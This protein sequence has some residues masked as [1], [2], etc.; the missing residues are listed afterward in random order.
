MSFSPLL[1]FAA[2]CWVA[3]KIGYACHDFYK[4]PEEVLP[5]LNALR[6]ANP[7]GNLDGI[8]IA[9]EGEKGE[10]LVLFSECIGWVG[11]KAIYRYHLCTNW[12]FDYW[13][14]RAYL[15][16]FIAICWK[17]GV[18][19]RG[20]YLPEMDIKRIASG[21]MLVCTE[22]GSPGVGGSRLWHP[23]DMALRPDEFI[24]G[25][26]SEEDQFGIKSALRLW[27]DLE[28][29]GY[30]DTGLA[31]YSKAEIRAAYESMLRN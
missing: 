10:A 16:A 29:Q 5:F 21:E 2:F 15:T 8:L 26:D 12:L 7:E 14:S 20:T 11:D 28:H 13:K 3:K 25:V 1:S 17:R 24:S 4:K 30:M 23:E 22:D 6:E 27:L 19:I 18:H 9:P 31:M